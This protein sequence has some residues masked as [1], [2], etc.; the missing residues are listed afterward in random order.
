MLETRTARWQA[1]DPLFEK[2]PFVSPYSFGLNNP[3]CIKDED[4]RDIVILSSPQGASGFGHAAVLIGNDEVGWNYFSKNGTYGSSG[5]SGASDKNPIIFKRFKTLAEFANSED[6]FNMN[7]GS[8]EYKAAFRITTTADVDKKVANAAAAQV[9][10]P[11]RVIG[12]SCVDVAS[13]ALDAG[14]MDPGHDFNLNPVGSGGSN[15][16]PPGPNDRYKLIMKNNKGHDVTGE[17]KPSEKTKSEMKNK[18]NES[19]R[20]ENQNAGR[21]TGIDPDNFTNGGVGDIR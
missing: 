7:D 3:I 14:G 10:K 5:A 6:N 15:N 18:S 12:Q 8:V 4:G 9:K 16:I 1:P 13:D 11:Y 17:I 21:E 19:L 20:I 2:Y